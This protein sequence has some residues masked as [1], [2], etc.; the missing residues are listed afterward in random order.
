[1]EVG[2]IKSQEVVQKMRYICM[3]NFTV[4]LLETYAMEM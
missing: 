1:M 3:N 4:H 2:Q